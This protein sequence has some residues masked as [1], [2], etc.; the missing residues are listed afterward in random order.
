MRLLLIRHGESEGNARGVVQGHM[1]FGLSAIGREQAAATAESVAR[2][3]VDRVISSPLRRASETALVIGTRLGLPVEP[4]R[5][6]MEYDIGGASGLTPA[7]IRVRHPEVLEAFARGE[8]PQYPGEEGREVFL[9]RVRGVLE[10]LMPLQETILAITHGGVI[11]SLCS[12]VM[13]I[14]GRRPGVFQAANCSITELVTD[15]AG[16]LVIRRHN[17]TCH[18]ASLVTTVDRG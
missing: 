12:D 5:G 2:E 4:E 13:G 9:A 15:R 10:Q 7:E 17:D 3:P 18:L 16:R 8:R 11:S 6:L 14:D 1:D